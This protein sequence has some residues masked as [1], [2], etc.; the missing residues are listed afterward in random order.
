MENIFF[1]DV[2]YNFDYIRNFILLKIHKKR[3]EIRNEIISRLSCKL[4]YGLLWI[5]SKA[6]RLNYVFTIINFYKFYYNY[7]KNLKKFIIFI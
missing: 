4:I 5:K 6:K 7:Y 2:Y 3:F 1:L